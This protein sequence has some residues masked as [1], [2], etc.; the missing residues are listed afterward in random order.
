VKHLPN[1]WLTISNEAK[2][3]N[4]PQSTNLINLIKRIADSINENEFKTR[5]LDSNAFKY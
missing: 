3:A 2:P 5:K 1:K 4:L